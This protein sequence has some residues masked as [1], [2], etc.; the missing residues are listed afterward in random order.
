[1]S[2]VQ[3]LRWRQWSGLLTLP[4]GTCLQEGRPGGSSG[5]AGSPGNRLPAEGQKQSAVPSLPKV[6]S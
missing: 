5:Q 4:A 1:M 6:P 2:Q 3:P